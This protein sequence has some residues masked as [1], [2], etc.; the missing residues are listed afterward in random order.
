MPA[1]LAAIWISTTPTQMTGAGVLTHAAMSTASYTYTTR[2]R[3]TDR[4][5]RRPSSKTP[6]PSKS[7]RN[8]AI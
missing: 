7:Y 4:T 2:E 8:T 3:I 5:R 6:T 1:G